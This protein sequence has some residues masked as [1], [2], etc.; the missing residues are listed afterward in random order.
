VYLWAFIGRSGEPAGRCLE[1]TA[2]EEVIE[3]K[4]NI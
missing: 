2:S 3:A 1:G 4:H